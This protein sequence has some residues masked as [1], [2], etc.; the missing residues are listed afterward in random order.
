[1]EFRFD[2]IQLGSTFDAHRLAQAARSSQGEDALVK[3]LFAAYFTEGKLLADHQ[4]LL[5]VA[6]AAGMDPDVARTVLAGDAHT[7][8]VRADEA[9][10]R[11]AGIT[12]VPHFVIDGKWAVPG[13]Q[14]VETMLLAL[15]RA[16][17][18]TEDPQAAATG[19]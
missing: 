15:R 5:D 11:E 10:A 3:G 14:D 7:D 1:M 16:W 18:R 13:A 8:A 17:E 4:V 9:V 19:A 12:G 6:T 2:R